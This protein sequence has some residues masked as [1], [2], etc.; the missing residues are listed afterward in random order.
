VD[1]RQRRFVKK[2]IYDN[3]AVYHAQ[4]DLIGGMIQRVEYAM[5]DEGVAEDVIRR[6][7]NLLAFG[8]PYGLDAVIRTEQ[9]D[10]LVRLLERMPN[11]G[12][13]AEIFGKGAAEGKPGV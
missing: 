10:Q 4:V 1:D 6:V 11:S 9:T 8:T 13:L 12:P 2:E 3:D 7:V 5:R